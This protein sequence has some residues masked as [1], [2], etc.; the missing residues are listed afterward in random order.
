[1]STIIALL[2]CRLSGLPISVLDTSTPSPQHAFGIVACWLDG[3]C[4]PRCSSSGNSVLF[5]MKDLVDHVRVPGRCLQNFGLTLPRR[6]YWPQAEQSRSGCRTV[7]LGTHLIK[8]A[9]HQLSVVD[10]PMPFWRLVHAV[11][12]G[13]VMEDHV[14]CSG[15]HKTAICAVWKGSIERLIC[16]VVSCHLQSCCGNDSQTQQMLAGASWADT[17]NAAI[18]RNTSCRWLLSQLR[19]MSRPAGRPSSGCGRPTIG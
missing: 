5:S 6:Q 13:P 3:V 18:V 14:G 15:L 19:R 17:S 11:S 16:V 12:A 1:M 4:G 2:V 8:A 10:Q 7:G 9:L